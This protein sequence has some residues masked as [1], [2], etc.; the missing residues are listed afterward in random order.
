ML[1][2]EILHERALR[3]SITYKDGMSTFQEVLHKYN[4]A[5]F[6]FLK[7]SISI[8]Y[9]N[10]QTLMKEIFKMQRHLFAEIAGNKF[11]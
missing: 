1:S 2:C 7:K 3:S 10:L 8:L 11:V 5:Y 4:S 6:F 9:K